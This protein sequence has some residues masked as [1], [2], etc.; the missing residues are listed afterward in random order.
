MSDGTI[1][2]SRWEHLGPTNDVKLF[3]MNP[4]CS[5]MLALAGQ[6]GKDF[7]SLVQVRE[8]TPGVFVGIA[9]AREGTIQAG[10]VMQID[11]HARRR[12]GVLDEQA[13]SF[14]SLTPRVPTGATRWCRAASAAIARRIVLGDGKY[15][16]LV[17]RRRRQRSQRARRDRARTSASTCTIRRPKSAYACTTTRSSGTCTRC[18]CVARNEPPVRARQSAGAGRRRDGRVRRQARRS[19]AR[20]TSPTPR[21]TRA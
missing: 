19:S 13:A 1:G 9:T 16:G 7:N 3:R 5:N 12:I 21:S 18:R 15:A 20:P 10:A 4:D 6:H 2:Y 11:A 14:T 8:A 17:G